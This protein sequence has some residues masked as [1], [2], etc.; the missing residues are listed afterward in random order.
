MTE[1]P[2]TVTQVPRGALAR[3]LDAIERIGNR[4]PDPAMLFLILLGIVALLSAWFSTLTFN[5]IDPRTREAIVIRNLL[6]P[7]NLTAFMSGMVKT[8][9]DFP[10]LGVVLVAM[11][12]IGV[13]EHTGFIH[14]ALK[15]LL[16]VTRRSLLTPVN[17]RMGNCWRSSRSSPGSLESGWMNCAAATCK[18]GTA[19]GWPPPE[20]RW[21]S[22]S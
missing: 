14:A 6:A 10:P 20:R 4:L 3:A 2:S 5:E 9:V 12:G 13:A 21:S 7:D 22:R 16:S 18:G 19:C 8:F 1:Q 17:G 11:L 15:A